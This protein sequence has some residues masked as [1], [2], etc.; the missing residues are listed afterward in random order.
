MVLKLQDTSDLC[1]P[2]PSDADFFTW[3][4]EFTGSHLYCSQV[5]A[6]EQGVVKGQVGGGRFVLEAQVDTITSE[7]GMSE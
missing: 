7:F 2:L 1:G 5:P 4:L 3:Q 6:G